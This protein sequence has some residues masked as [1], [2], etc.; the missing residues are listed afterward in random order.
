LNSNSY[1]DP[2]LHT[3]S[4]VF[5]SDGTANLYSKIYS[6]FS[7]N[8]LGFYPHSVNDVKFFIFDDSIFSNR[9]LQNE[10]L[11]VG[12]FNVRSAKS[13]YIGQ[14]VTQLKPSGIF[15][16]NS[17]SGRSSLI[18]EAEEGIIPITS[19]KTQIGGI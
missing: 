12:L 6:F 4:I 10:K 11:E 17:N 15:E 3:P 9:Y 2:N 1:L 18:T 8:V 13:I 16:I 7:S 5:N 19:K 14:S